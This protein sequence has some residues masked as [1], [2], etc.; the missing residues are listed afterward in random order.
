MEVCDAQG[1]PLRSDLI[2][3]IIVRTDLVPVPSTVEIE[4][5]RTKET[6]GAIVENQV[7]LVGASRT[8]YR[9]VKVGSTNG[10]V[11]R[12]DREVE[13]IRA[14]G[15]LDS[16][17]ALASRLQRSI[18]REGSTFA[19]I[20][21]AIGSTAQI[22]SD[23]AVPRFA[24]LIGCIPTPEIA[25][26]LQ[27]EAA[28]VFLEGG[29]IK[30][31]RLAE[32]I[33]APAQLTFQ[34]D[35]T[36]KVSSQLLD[37]HAVPFAFSTSA[38]NKIIA[39][40]RESGRGVCYRPRADVRILNNMG[41]ALVQR[42]KMRQALSPTLNAGARIDIAGMPH[43]VITAAHVRTNGENGNGGE[44]YSQIWLGELVR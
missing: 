40:K 43:I 7:V 26:V 34:E 22:D 20:Y 10:E 42:R 17:A 36:E 30:F 1:V 15:I 14:V 37:R 35:R 2:S 5:T 11:Q 16:C 4:A 27:E 33:A 25:K 13:T 38:D 28:V 18:I 31:R 23:F 29:K 32:L 41:V 19:E 8:P 9:L 39:T 44:E 24:A 3:R 12:G 6:T 21:R